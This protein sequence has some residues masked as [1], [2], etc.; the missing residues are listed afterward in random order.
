VD[1]DLNGHADGR[2]Q[3]GRTATRCVRRLRWH[4]FTACRR[5]NQQYEQDS[6]RSHR[7]DRVNIADAQ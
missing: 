6:Q 1:F 3:T 5:R 4:G 2:A 7:Y